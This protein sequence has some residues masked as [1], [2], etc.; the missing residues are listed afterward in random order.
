LRSC[1]YEGTV[2]HRRFE[3]VK[4]AFTYRQ[5]MM[6]LDLSELEQVLA[7][8]VLWSK[9]RIAPA[10]FDR[11]DYLGDASIPLDR[12]VRDR[13]ESS[14]GHRPEGPIRLLTHLRYFG[15]CFNPVSFYYCYDKGD[16][17]VEAIVAEITNTPWKERHA[18]VL[19]RDH[20]MPESMPLR[21][22]F[23]KEFHV[24]PFMDMQ[25]NY[26]WR[27]TEP[28]SR[29]F[30]H[31]ENYDQDKRIFDATLTLER[32]EITTS[33]LTCC[34]VR[35]PFMTA[36]VIGAI[37]YQALRLW[38]KRCPFYPHPSKRGL[39]LKETVHG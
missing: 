15:Y 2:R 39:E 9:H 38:W 22:Q 30:V 4:N 3:P 11:R 20:N 33:S 25:M 18:Y 13:V 14:V 29:L 21:Y 37:H 32:K 6:F 8:N 19:S 5:F 16:C 34:L 10:R 31:M 23:D 24:S 7:L 17:R 26:D 35:Y 28:N 27:F 36:Q 12:A 1:I